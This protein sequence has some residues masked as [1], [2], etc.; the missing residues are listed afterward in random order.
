M[1]KTFEGFLFN[2]LEM[3]GDKKYNHV[4]CMGGNENFIDFLSQFV[5][6]VGMK[7]KVKFTVESKEE[8]KIVEEYK[9]YK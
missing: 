5:S 2:K 3:L 4:G 9:N 8:P 6:E 1:K 7:R